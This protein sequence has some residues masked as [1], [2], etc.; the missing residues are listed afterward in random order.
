MNRDP[1]ESR[2]HQLSGHAYVGGVLS[3]LNHL[4]L[5]SSAEHAEWGDRLM[6]VLGDPPGGWI[7]VND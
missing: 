2:E 1:A 5:L 7:D 6:N 3:T 4:G